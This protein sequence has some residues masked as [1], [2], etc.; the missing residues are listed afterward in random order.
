MRLKTL[1]G[2]ERES[3]RL[4][5]L[6]VEDDDTQ[7]EVLCEVIQREGYDPVACMSA[8]EVLALTGLADFAVAIVDLRLPDM[9]GTGS[10][11]VFFECP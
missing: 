5:V 8:A 11:L 3:S 1:P 10:W 9:D 2:V 6:I 7:R 4:R